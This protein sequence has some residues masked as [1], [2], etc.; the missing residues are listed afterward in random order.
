MN[1]Q[2]ALDTYL[3]LIEDELRACLAMPDGGVPDYFG[4]LHYHLGWADERFQPVEAR[5]GK[6]IRPVFTLLACRAAGGEPFRALPAAAAVE[7][8]HNF[9]LIHDDIED[10]SNTRRGRRTVWSWW[11]VPQAINAGDGMF[12][13]AFLALHRLAHQ[14]VAA[15]RVAQASRIL[16]ETC[17]ALCQGQHLDLAF[18]TSPDVG[19][20]DYMRMIGGKTA[21]L[22]GCA[23]HLG[24]VVA[25]A[26]PAAGARYRR[27]GE[28]LGTAFQ[29]QDDV[30]GIWGDAAVTGKPVADDIRSRK[31]TLPVLYALTRPG[32]AGLTA[33]HAQPALTDVQVE[34]IKTLLAACGAREHAEQLADTYLERA[35]AELE[36]AQPE[37]EAGEALRELARALVQRAA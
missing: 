34:E 9:S 16:A 7:I 11:G 20:E 15:E 28:L 12:A 22:L 17:V 10:G 1:L 5:T 13:L 27:V 26:P 24:A 6:R 19:V 2:S 18:E 31:K 23:A 30:L 3:P 14:G 32:A 21:A 4:M 36:A 8:I 25:G 33:L 29:I 35:L 37:P